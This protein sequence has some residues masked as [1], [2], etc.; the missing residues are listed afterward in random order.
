MPS[1]LQAVLQILWVPRLLHTITQFWRV[2]RLPLAHCFPLLTRLFLQVILRL[3]QLIVLNRYLSTMLQLARLSL[4]V[5]R[6]LVKSWSRFIRWQIRMVLGCSVISGRLGGQIL[7]VLLVIPLP[8]L[9]P[10]LEKQFL[11][12]SAIP[13][14]MARRRVSVALIL[15]LFLKC[16]RVSLMWS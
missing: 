7:L 16:R 12:M 14:D 9:R 10:R 1:I 13:M 15:W 2:K 3:R 6:P 11:F 5:Y 4:Q 8:S